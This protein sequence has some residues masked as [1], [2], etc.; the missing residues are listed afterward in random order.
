[1]KK[2]IVSRDCGFE[3]GKRLLANLNSNNATKKF[4]TLEE[5]TKDCNERNAMW[6]MSNPSYEIGIFKVY[7]ENVEEKT[8]EIVWGSYN[9]KE[10]FPIK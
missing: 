9:G 3:M 5:A 1:M 2:Y 4:E 7:C 10:F 6:R 8:A